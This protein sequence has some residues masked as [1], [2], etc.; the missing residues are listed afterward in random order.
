MPANSF[1]GRQHPLVLQPPIILMAKPVVLCRGD[2]VESLAVAPVK[3]RALETSHEKAP[4]QRWL[5][6]TLSP[7]RI[8]PL[9]GFHQPTFFVPKMPLT[10]STKSIHSHCHSMR[11][12]FRCH[13]AS[14]HCHC[15]CH[16]HC[17][18]VPR[19]RFRSRGELR[20]ARRAAAF[21]VLPG[22]PLS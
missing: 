22:T 14:G 17:R 9:C 8:D 4:E 1:A 16:W 13:S 7:D 2:E 11:G 5:G 20:L 10:C 19:V 6:A 15:H 18:P 12:H 3:R 21:C